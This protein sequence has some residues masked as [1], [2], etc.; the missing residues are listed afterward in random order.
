MITINDI[1]NNINYYKDSIKNKN[2]SGYYDILINQYTFS[3]KVDFTGFVEYMKNNDSKNGCNKRLKRIKKQGK[4]KVDNKYQ[5][6]FYSREEALDKNRELVGDLSYLRYNALGIGTNKIKRRLNKLAKEDILAKTLR[7]AMEIEDVN[8]LA[9]KY[10]GS[11]RNKYYEKKAVLINDLIDIFKKNEWIYGVHKSD[12]YETNSII[13]FEIPNT[14]QIS[15]HTNINR[16]LPTY[17][18]KWDG[19]RN[20]TYFKLIESIGEIFSDIIY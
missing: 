17:N 3:E 16:K 11:Y 15:F 5:E 18:K 10:Y 6:D 7:L 20:S 12:G 13:F 1:E 8:I 2:L 4:E 19:K 9:K 14:E